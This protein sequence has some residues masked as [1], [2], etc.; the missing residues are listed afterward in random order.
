MFEI[1]SRR[2][3][4]RNIGVL[5]SFIAH[6][7]V[8][9]VLVRRQP[10]FVKPSSVA[11]GRQHT[12][13][14]LIYAPPRPEVASNEHPK[15]RLNLKPKPAPALLPRPVESSRAGSPNGSLFS[16]PGKGIEAVPAIPL[17]FPDPDVYPW[18][19]SD[20]R[21]DV[22]VEIT[23]DEKGSVSNTRLLQ[24]LKQDV[25]EKCIATLRNW[26]FRPA[27]VDGV[28]IAS[29]QDVHFHFPS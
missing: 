3:S 19:V 6:L 7:A 8:L 17:Q 12:S 21:G 9:F 28:A 10:V 29:R 15:L 27:M 4:H 18:Q 5:F 1:P 2:P 26:R 25:D 16:G 20:V 14:V 24:S 13:G 22:V 11:W 23:I